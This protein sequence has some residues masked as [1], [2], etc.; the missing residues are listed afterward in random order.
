MWRT[1]AWFLLGIASVAAGCAEVGKIKG[2]KME[3]QL[4]KLASEY[5]D[6]YSSPNEARNSELGFK[7][8]DL[9]WEGLYLAAPEKV[10]A[11]APGIPI[12]AMMR[13]SDLHEWEARLKKNSALVFTNLESGT[14]GMRPLYNPPVKKMKPQPD[15]RGR[16]PEADEGFV[17]GAIHNEIG[18]SQSGPLPPGEYTVALI[19]WDRLTNQRRVLKEGRA[20][21][22]DLVAIAAS[23]PWER[24]ADTQAFKAG[25][26]SPPL[27]AS[28]GVAVKVAGQKDAR[29]VS[30]TL[31]AKARAINLIPQDSKRATPSGIQA[32]VDVLLLL[33]SLDKYPP[34]SVKIAVPILGAASINVGDVMKGWFTLPFPFQPSAEERMLYAVVDG[35]VSGPLRVPGEKP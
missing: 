17:A 19:A 35:Q 33:F 7:I 28:N 12:L 20:G 13:R 3:E 25:P 22:V 26:A 8:S 32:G 11:A 31:A 5:R 16:K 9:E 6:L 34:E 15:A 24:W 4:E 1:K 29:I 23:W 10:D 27:D 30:G 2:K 21:P 18:A 14:T